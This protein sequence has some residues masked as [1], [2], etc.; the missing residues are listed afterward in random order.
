[1]E[2]GQVQ[3]PSKQ[4]SQEPG[5]ALE[6]R[7]V[8]PIM[9]HSRAWGGRDAEHPLS[10]PTGNLQ[11]PQLRLVGGFVLGLRDGCLG[12]RCGSIERPAQPQSLPNSEAKLGF[13]LRSSQATA[14]PSLGVSRCV[15][16]RPDSDHSPLVTKFSNF[17]FPGVYYLE[18]L[19]A[20]KQVCVPLETLWVPRGFHTGGHHCLFHSGRA[21]WLVSWRRVRSRYLLIQ[22]LSFK[23]QARVYGFKLWT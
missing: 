10:D 15:S 3:S 4:E 11:A 19:K 16:G 14:C 8:C 5:V 22:T 1:M 13:C 7:W 6:H 20:R 2:K 17:H 18:R 21:L 23:E 9:I 12:Q